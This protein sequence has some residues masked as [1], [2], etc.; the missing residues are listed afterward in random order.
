MSVGPPVLSDPLGPPFPVFAALGPPCP[1][2]CYLRGF[3][4][5]MV[6]GKSLMADVVVS[7]T[8][9][10]VYNEPLFCFCVIV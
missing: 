5:S 8:C 7:F 10:Y 6:V 9:T 4:I 1:Y 3:C 2:P